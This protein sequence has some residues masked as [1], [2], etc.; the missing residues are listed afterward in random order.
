MSF[1][2]EALAAAIARHG[3]VARVVIATG[4]GS[5]PREPGTAMLVWSDGQSGTIGGGA[6]E[7]QA[8]A[9]AREALATG[10][11][12]DKVPLGPALGQCCGGAVVLVTEVW[13]RRPARRG[14]RCRGAALSGRDQRHAPCRGTTA[15]TGP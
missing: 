8:V 7:F 11:R 3:R 6:L 15:A 1:D 5:T 2:R 10:D 14:R 13:D 12:C 4:A 9:R